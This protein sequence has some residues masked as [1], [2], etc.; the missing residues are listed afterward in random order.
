MTASQKIT[1]AMTRRIEIWPI[2]RLVPYARNVRTH[3]PEQVAQIAERV[4]AEKEWRGIPGFE[5]YEASSFGRIRRVDS[6]RVLKP[7]IDSDGRHRVNL[8]RANKYRTRRVHQLVALAFHGPQPDGTEVAHLDGNVGNNR[9]SNLAWCTPKENNGH[10]RIHGTQPVG[11]RVWNAKMTDAQVRLLKATYSGQPGE[12]VR[13]ARSIGV[14][15][16]AVRN[17]LHGRTWRD[18]A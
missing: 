8:W 13:F 1:P 10:K 11:E 4:D 6:G 12:I 5:E 16:E 7:V 3:S 15:R 9:P 17:A 14:S 18:I 2:D